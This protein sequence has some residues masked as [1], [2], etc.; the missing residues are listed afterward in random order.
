MIRF[1]SC[2]AITLLAL[3]CVL[4]SCGPIEPSNL[5]DN[6]AYHYDQL[7]VMAGETASLVWS[8]YWEGD[9]D[10]WRICFS[11]VS[12]D[13]KTLVGIK[14]I[15]A[16]YR[17]SCA[18]T[19]GQYVLAYIDSQSNRCLATLDAEGQVVGDI[20]RSEDG[21]RYRRA[22]LQPHADGL[23]LVSSSSS[24]DPP[25]TT[26]LRIENLE[27]GILSTA[28]SVFD[29]GMNPTFESFSCSW[30]GDSCGIA[31]I[32]SREEPAQLY[33]AT[34]KRD[35][36]GALSKESA[37]LKISDG[38]SACS[39][40][41][42]AYSGSEFGLMWW[43][44]SVRMACLGRDGAVKGS[45]ASIPAAFEGFPRSHGTIAWGGSEFLFAWSGITS[46]GGSNAVDLYVARAD[47]SG[48]LK[49]EAENVS[50][51]DGM[52]Q[53][54]FVAW[55]GSHYCIS[56]TYVPEGWSAGD[57]SGGSV[58]HNPEIYLVFKK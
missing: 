12:E 8:E 36:D 28:I 4:S 52:V 45:A 37:D 7:V 3:G 1:R 26:E 16:G 30:A 55:T 40:P 39:G 47:A 10:D 14:T 42:L 53:S 46:D 44:A 38:A 34:I 29:A 56:W 23:I 58:S 13:G 51:A 6:G 33:F 54:P 27:N 31:W 57:Y 21:R 35:A 18:W 24:I 15:D 43:E 20:V 9:S 22:L 48:T 49:G 11:K 50:N 41:S 32:D 25:S 19:G 17:P 5:T 2:A